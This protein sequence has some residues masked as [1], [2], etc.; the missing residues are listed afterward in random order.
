MKARRFFTLSTA[1]LLAACASKTPSLHNDLPTN[2]DSSLPSSEKTDAEATTAL[3]NNESGI[4]EE[5][6]KALANTDNKTNKT[7]KAAAEKVGKTAANKISSWEISG[8]M[9]AKSKN[10]AW[11]A[12]VN[13]VQQGY[14]YY[15][16]RLFGPLG[17]GTI[18]IQKQGSKISYRDGPKSAT[19]SNAEQLL[20]QQTGVRLPVSSLYY[21]VRGVPAPGSIQSASKD[22]AGYLSVL[23]QGGYTIQYLGYTKAGSAYLPSQIKLQGNGIFIKF[24]I[25]HWRV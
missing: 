23:K 3:E 19:S 17:S 8:A 9:A 1:L 6:T 25:K 7:E 21:W 12:S 13:W 2:L 5:N 22:S 24:I 14:N 11:S 4:K 18:M 16:I 15:Q 20:L 10:K